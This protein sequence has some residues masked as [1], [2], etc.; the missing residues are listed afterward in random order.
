MLYNYSY[1]VCIDQSHAIEQYSIICYGWSLKQE[2]AFFLNDWQQQM[3]L[4]MIF[5][6]INTGLSENDWYPIGWVLEMIEVCVI[7]YALQITAIVL[8]NA[9]FRSNCALLRIQM[10][11]LTWLWSCR[12]VSRAYAC[13]QLLDVCVCINEYSTKKQTCAFRWP[14]SE[15]LVMLGYAADLELQV[16]DVAFYV[17]I[18]FKW[19]RFCIL[20]LSG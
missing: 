13:R 7:L 14:A 20:M 4:G 18:F 3:V 1:V 10:N 2:C 8:P 9:A 15:L 12:F 16:T 17:E 11:S 6:S 5:A 19:F